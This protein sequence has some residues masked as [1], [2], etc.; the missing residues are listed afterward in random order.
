MTGRNKNLDLV[1]ALAIL[2]VLLFHTAQML[3]LQDSPIWHVVQAGKAG[4]DLF[5]VLSGFLI[6]GL[7]WRERLEFGNV[8]GARFILRRALRTMPP[9][10]VALLISWLAVHAVRGDAFDPRY[11][12]F[13]QNYYERIPYFLVSWSLCIEEHFYVLLPFVLGII[14]L[15]KVR[16]ARVVLPL[17][18]L[19][20][21]ILRCYQ[22][23]ASMSQDFGYSWTATHLRCEGLI[24]GV[25]AAYLVQYHRNRMEALLRAKVPIYCAAV[26]FAVAMPLLPAAL[27]YTAGY[28][29]LSVLLTLSVLVCAL[30]R[31]YRLSAVR[32]TGGLAVASYSMYL[33]H[34][35]AIHACLRS[36]RLLPGCAVL[37]K[38]SLMLLAIIAA[39]SAYYWLVE[40]PS[41]WLRDQ[42]VRR[43]RPRAVG[44]PASTPGAA[45]SE[46]EA[47]TASD[48]DAPLVKSGQR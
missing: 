12:C 48:S 37:G 19:A 33:T 4:V 10:F 13:L 35:F 44:T 22:Y 15:G 30:D 16:M 11:L 3:D 1:R 2:M 47:R 34:P 18:A 8:H 45:H 14:C 36:Y 9:Y 41:F 42:L 21:G 7:Y 25:F 40:R 38:W 23:R 39:G 24:L 46:L 31:P 6:G 29:V 28:S 17:L 32:L 5:F 43:R 27:S 20:P 26:G